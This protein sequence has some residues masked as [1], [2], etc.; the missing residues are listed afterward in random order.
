[1]R[2]L[3]LANV[4]ILALDVCLLSLEFAALW[5]VWCTFKGFAYSIKLKIE[6]AILNQLRDTITNPTALSSAGTGT[7]HR[8]ST[9]VQQRQSQRLSAGVEGRGEA[10]L[11]SLGNQAQCFPTGLGDG[12]ADHSGCYDQIRKTTEYTISHLDGGEEVEKAGTTSRPQSTSP[13]SS[14]VECATT[15]A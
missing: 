9:A 5:G 2:N 3:L 13:A 6:F 4:A 8:T 10:S 7:V 14:E 15:D 12:G 1:M 11:T